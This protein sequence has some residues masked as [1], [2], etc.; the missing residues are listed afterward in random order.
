MASFWTCRHADLKDLPL[1]VQAQTIKNNGKKN[2]YIHGI[3]EDLPLSQAQQV[4]FCDV[5]ILPGQEVDLTKHTSFH[6]SISYPD[7]DVTIHSDDEVNVDII[8]SDSSSRWIVDTKHPWNGAPLPN[9]TYTERFGGSGMSGIIAKVG[10]VSAAIPYSSASVPVSV[11]IKLQPAIEYIRFDLTI[12]SPKCTCGQHSVKG[13]GKHSS[14]CDLE[15]K[16]L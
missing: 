13:G 10:N 3:E 14:W 4:T 7:F 2:I 6:S 8:S 1:K 9:G 12:T 5:C 15:R 16:T 11:S